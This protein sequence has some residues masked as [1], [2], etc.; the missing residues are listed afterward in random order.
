MTND[1]HHIKNDLI[2]ACRQR[3]EEACRAG[4]EQMGSLRMSLGSEVKS[5]AGD[6]HETGRAMIQLE[7]ERL[8]SRLNLQEEQ[9]SL[10]ERL[11]ATGNMAPTQVAPGRMVV[12]DK[13]MYFIAVSLGPVTLGNH[14]VLVISP[15]SPVGQA[16]IGKGVGD[17]AVFNAQALRI[18]AI[19]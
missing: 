8:A 3:L 17:A 13:G 18:T 4:R 10:F 5:S 2:L 14:T 15:V 6:K 1:L 12:T 7:M 16:L 11:V 9:L 19:V